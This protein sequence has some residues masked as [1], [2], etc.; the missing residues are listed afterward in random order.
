MFN[1]TQ[2]LK[3]LSRFFQCRVGSIINLKQT[4]M[5]VTINSSSLHI[6]LKKIMVI[7]WTT[8]CEVNDLHYIICS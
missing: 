8:A 3:Y 6:I 2:E 1:D 7:I 5:D 4:T